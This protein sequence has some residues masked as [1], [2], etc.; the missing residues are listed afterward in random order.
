MPPAS[1][2]LIF[3]VATG[4]VAHAQN[5]SPAQAVG[6]LESRCGQCHSG[7]AAMSGF[8]IAT[9]E[10]LLKGGSRGA[11]VQ[12]GHATESILYQ[13]VT[14]TGK[15][16]MPPGPGL[17]EQEIKLLRDWIDQGAGWPE[18]ITAPKRVE[19]WAFQKPQRPAVPADAQANPIDA[20]ILAKLRKEN[21]Q[22]SAE[23]TRLA[24]LRR[25]TFDLLGLPPTAEQT[26]TFLA[27]SRPDAWERLIDSLLASPHYGEKWGRYWLDLV[28]YGDTSGFEQDPYLLD[29]W[30][31]RDWVIKSLNDDKPYDRFAE[32]Q[33]AGDELWPE[34]VDARTGTGYYR[35]GVNR[36]LLFKVEDQNRVEKLTDYV[37]TTSEVFLGLSVGCA[38]CHDHKFDPIPQRDF[39]R[40]QA[41]FAPLVYDRTFLE[42]NAGRNYDLAVVGREFKLRQIGEQITRIER[43][44][45]EKLRAEKI[46]KLSEPDRAVLALKP[47][48]RTP[49]QQ[50]AA[51][52]LE[53]KVSVSNDE[54]RAAMSQDDTERLH[55][56]EKRLV[57][58]FA[59]YAPAPMVPSVTDIGREAP[60]TFI[61]LRGNPTAYGDEVGPGFLSV[62][63]GG[64][65]PEPPL[66][67]ETTGR[68]KAL[69]TWLASSDN[70]LFARVM[71]NRIW[72]GHFGTGLVRTSSD[73]GV[74]AG[75]PG[76]KDLLDW[77]SVEFAS[78]KWS[79]K[80]MH[81]LI[82]TSEAYRRSADPTPSARE[83]DP[84]NELFS[85]MNR[86][87]LQSEE[88]H[89][90]V[91]QVS[92][93]L[94]SKMGGIPIVPP[95]QTE[96]LY[97]MI[98]KP[99]NNWVVSPDP[100]QFSR[101]SIY[102]LQRRTFQQPMFEALDSPDGVQSCPR[103]NESTTAPQSLA[104]LN[105]DF[106][107]GQAKKMAA[108][109]QSVDEIWT[110]VLGRPPSPEERASATK[111]IERQTQRL[112]S[113]EAAYTELARALMNLNEFLYVE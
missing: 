61:A 76:N 101:R 66:H 64:D 67:A 6:L 90:G 71:V 25:A 44:Y 18:N 56:I 103:R 85:H 68:R 94:N 7:K 92:G 39:Y 99:E 88:I 4:A 24:L 21:V 35:V 109:V 48:S 79:M 75:V 110:R 91:L 36:D 1:G 73:F 49:E 57:T 16:T 20:F 23:A 81:K 14:H 53:P 5:V 28:R 87:R 112:G 29:A 15:L 40:M 9:R 100:E 22:P 60:K 38:R 104:L 69:A 65:V 98:G 77:L 37:G 59:N 43:P 95:L 78:R 63:G 51:L 106:I 34:E 11:A 55:G 2:V 96:E 27:D 93:T 45:R 113:K 52:Q 58:M 102:M 10:S 105:G 54:I 80:S 12:P 47:E 89:D 72:Q 62:L 97:G 70:P 50:S 83:K 26:Q 46:A 84:A 111:L 17:S 42:Y 19:W 31:Y 33:I 13:A 82:M 30:R 74:R 3:L 32:E 107:M 108:K 8:S 41:I 86:R